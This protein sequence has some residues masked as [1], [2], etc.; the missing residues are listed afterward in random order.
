MAEKT[1]RNLKNV[2]KDELAK[3]LL[4]M[5]IKVQK[6]KSPV[7]NKHELKEGTWVCKWCGMDHPAFDFPC[8]DRYEDGTLV[9]DEK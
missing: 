5:E 9:K 1:V 2:T 8:V 6:L 3:K 4:N 7:I